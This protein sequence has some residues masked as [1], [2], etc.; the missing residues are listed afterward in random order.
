[1]TPS[2]VYG[3]LRWT[4]EM[5]AEIAHAIEAFEDRIKELAPEMPLFPEDDEDD[6]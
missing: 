6:E 3:L 2:E 4:N 5:R 1:M